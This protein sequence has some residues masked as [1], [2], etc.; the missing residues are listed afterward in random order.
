MNTAVIKARNI[1]AQFPKDNFNYCF[2]YGSGIFK[3]LGKTGNPMIDLVLV[4]NN[5]CNFHEDNL[6]QRRWHYSGLK[7]AKPSTI[8]KVQEHWGAKIYYNTLIHSAE[9]N[10]TYKYGVISRE[11]FITDLLDWCH[12]YISGRLHKPVA[13]LHQCTDEETLNAL[14]NNLFSAV[15]VA[16]LT[17]P[18]TFTEVEFYQTI[19]NISYRGDF[20][21]WLGEDKNKV[22]KIVL[23]Q[24]DYF[25]E[26]YQNV[27][28][29]LTDFLYIPDP[30]V[31]TTCQQ[32]VS[33]EARWHHLN[34]LPGV[35]QKELVKYFNKLGR[36]RKD[37]EEVLQTMSYDPDVGGVLAKILEKIVLS[38][39]IRQSLKG[40][41]TAGVVKS[42]KYGGRKVYKALLSLNH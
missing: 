20:R 30:K 13:V 3:Q 26:L 25:R 27:I 36:A 21:M 37:T 14:R 19:A 31:S 35:P 18:E 17:L 6:S 42:V 39:S 7:Y 38:S 15:H 16:L 22:K 11:D 8:S 40:I 24:I 41:L 4:V 23:P 5:S 28:S 34:N 32:N 10:V 2:C 12:L 33:P 29:S 1:L 9:E